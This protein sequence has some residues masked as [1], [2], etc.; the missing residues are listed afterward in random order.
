MNSETWIVRHFWRGIPLLNHILGWPSLKEL[1]FAHN[2]WLV[3]W[4][5]PPW[6]VL[7][8]SF[9][10]AEALFVF[11][12][13]FRH[14]FWKKKTALN[15]SFPGFFP[16]QEWGIRHHLSHLI[17]YHTGGRLSQERLKSDNFL[18]FL[19]D[20]LEISKAEILPRSQDCSISF[21]S[22]LFKSKSPKF[23][24]QIPSWLTNSTL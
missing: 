23:Y 9:A 24:R 1:Q 13:V 15:K 22:L 5:C 6:T 2:H 3:C 20:L 14:G 18:I 7:S 16:P 11:F 19:S 12:F 4:D 21:V 17:A 8:S 10:L